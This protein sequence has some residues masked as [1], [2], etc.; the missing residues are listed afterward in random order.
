MKNTIYIF[1]IILCYN[2][3]LQAQE[4]KY[5]VKDCEG[6][7]AIPEGLTSWCDTK[8]YNAC[9]C[10]YERALA[11]YKSEKKKVAS[12]LYSLNKKK[13]IAWE[14]YQN[15]MNEAQ[16][17]KDKL[18]NDNP[19]Y[20]ADKAKA[21]DALAEAKVYAQ[22]AIYEQEEIDKLGK[23]IRGPQYGLGTTAMEADLENVENSIAT[24]NKKKKVVTQ[25]VAVTTPQNK[26]PKEKE[27]PTTK[28]TVQKKDSPT[29]SEYDIFSGEI[30][31]SPIKKYNAHWDR[32]STVGYMVHKKNDKSKKIEFDS[33]GEFENGLF[34]LAN[35]IDYTETYYGKMINSEDCYIYNKKNG[36]LL[37]SEIGH[38]ASDKR[39][40]GKYK[41]SLFFL[42]KDVGV[43]TDENGQK[44]FFKD[45][46]IPE[47][48]YIILFRG[49]DISR[50]PNSSKLICPVKL[51]VTD[52]EGKL[53]KTIT[54]GTITY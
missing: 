25:K 45:L 11:T 54:K 8:Y 16:K 40:L 21:L 46:G 9:E 43:Y 44:L 29:N 17:Y 18:N 6:A 41:E 53:I 47:D 2:F 32:K 36:E 50:D 1:L 22:K 49:K 10:N 39:Y 42:H 19:N 20:E 15:S 14:K 3:S 12:E 23:R 13:D 30:E 5:P 33:A 51:Y 35:N 31:I 28:K 27:Q 7:K 52:T 37:A 48:S 4:L 24:T 26:E 34:I 38:T